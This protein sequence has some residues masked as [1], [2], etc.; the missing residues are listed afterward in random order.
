M[1]SHHQKDFFESL[2]QEPNVNL[3]V[4]YYGKVT[5]GR[6]GLGWESD[7]VGSYPSLRIKNITQLY[8]LIPDWKERIHILPGFSSLFLIKLLISF[9]VN[10]ITWFHW[11]ERAGVGLMRL[12]SFNKS[13][14]NYTYP[15]FLFIKGYYGYAYLVN[16]FSKGSFAIGDLAKEDFIK[17]G[18]AKENIKILPY[19]MNGFYKG[20]KISVGFPQRITFL[21][22]G[23]INHLKGIDLLLKAADTLRYRGYD[24]L[25]KI[26][27]PDIDNYNERN[28][29][30]NVQFLGVI[31]NNMLSQ[32]FDE[33]DVFVF[34]T[35]FDGW[36]AVLN[37]SASAGKAI[38]SSSQAGGASHLVSQNK[39]GYIFNS[40]DLERL[41]Q[42]M[43]YY[44]ED[45]S[46]AKEH[47]QESLSIFECYLPEKM[48]KNL[49]S[50]LE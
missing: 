2:S 8:S 16:K 32:I 48:A 27:G 22:I 4:C 29:C 13:L 44:I 43:T 40:E 19:S 20:N 31:D 39:N 9:I 45:I 49:I 10:R 28:V 14:F 18:V 17:W 6:K 24:F 42:Y 21:Y 41:I 1:P 33:S 46:L 3:I 36:G 37:E 7:L 34:P 25:V 26:V 11:S 35:R 50:W 38:I 23:S 30:E 12:V 5:K 47:G 15:L